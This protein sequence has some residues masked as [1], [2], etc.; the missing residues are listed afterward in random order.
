MS[1]QPFRRTLYYAI[2]ASARG[3]EADTVTQNG[4]IIDDTKGPIA[5]HNDM[6]AHVRCM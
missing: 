3:L 2:D 4:N 6:R 1:A 5:A